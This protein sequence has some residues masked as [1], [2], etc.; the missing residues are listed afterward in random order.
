MDGV[1]GSDGVN[2]LDGVNGEDGAE[3]PT[4]PTGPAGTDGQS[5][6]FQGEWSDTETY[7]VGD[8]V[9]QLSGT[10]SSNPEDPPP[11]TLVYISL[12]DNNTDELFEEASWALLV[13]DGDRGVTGP[14]GAT[15]PLPD[16]VAGN[17]IQYA[18]GIVEIDT[19]V[20]ATVSYVDDIA[21]GIYAKPA[22][23]AAT[24]ENLAATYNNG[25]LGVGS[26][27]TATSNGAFPAI[28]DV[29]TITTENGFR[30]VLVKNQ[31][32][33]A[34]NGRY[35]LTT[36]GDSGTP[37]VLTKCGLCDTANE[38]PGMYVFIKDGTVNAGK[39]F[40]GLVADPATFVV[41]TDAVNFTEFTSATTGPTGPTGPQGETGPEGPPGVPGMD[42]VNGSDGVNGEN[43]APGAD[44]AT[45]PTG[46]AGDSVSF[47][48]EWS[49]LETYSIGDI[50]SVPGAI[51]GGGVAAPTYTYISLVD[52][53][54][55]S[56][57]TTA[58]WAQLTKDG[59][60]GATGPT[61]ATGADAP[62]IVSFNQQTG[63]S[64]TLVLS[65]KD[66]M[67]ELS[68][69]SAITLTV[70]TNSA[71]EFPIG[72]DVSILQTGAGRITVV[73]ASGVT[74]NFT[75]SNQTRATWSS[76]SLIKRD[77][78]TWVLIGDLL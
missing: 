14:T 75:P 44:G 51:G 8:I 61:G 56:T 3:G 67:V 65:D 32:N 46:P 59:E 34:H 33:A 74:L 28:D 72:A 69:A 70:P 11:K 26:T 53:N 27:L 60:Q 2:G 78:N 5:V 13:Q 18:D 55:D 7:S 58:S 48:G 37:W 23:M 66:K 57:E 4:G 43:G 52:N 68:N 54:T 38:V 24:T 62:T 29:T 21:Q 35:N 73:P 22:V 45:G 12:V 39:G 64:Y 30:G 63:T 9:T 41:G 19:A 76:A 17:G 25:T 42:G 20:V 50:V 15:G 71:Q 40:V 1:N 16:F 36:Q 31:T 77:T 49:T 6:A 47:Q 10:A